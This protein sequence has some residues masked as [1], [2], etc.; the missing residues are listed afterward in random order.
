M[1]LSTAERLQSGRYKYALKAWAAPPV[2][3]TPLATS[4]FPFTGAFL[5]YAT[6]LHLLILN[7]DSF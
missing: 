7:N 3:S 1:H 2:C 5:L 6:Q 4:Q